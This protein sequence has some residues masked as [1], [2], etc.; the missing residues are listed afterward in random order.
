MPAQAAVQQYLVG[1]AAAFCHPRD[2]SRLVVALIPR[3]APRIIHV[4]SSIAHA[5]GSAK[6]QGR[7]TMKKIAIA[8]QT[9]ETSKDIRESFR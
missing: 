8:Q 3:T 9:V 1:S 6:H 5:I 7:L 4:A 2:L